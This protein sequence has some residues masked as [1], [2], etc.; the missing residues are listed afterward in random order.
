MRS[1]QPTAG[2]RMQTTV[3]HDGIA[4]IT[5]FDAPDLVDRFT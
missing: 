2:P 3:R 4:A 5:V 1:T